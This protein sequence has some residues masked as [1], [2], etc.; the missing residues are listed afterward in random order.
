[1][2]LAMMVRVIVYCMVLGK[3]HSFVKA[4]GPPNWASF[5][6]DINVNL[7]L[8][9]FLAMNFEKHLHTVHALYKGIV[10][11]RAWS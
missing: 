2:I 6:V 4:P 8:H 7:L 10:Y 1:M 9:L 3:L 11:V 5:M